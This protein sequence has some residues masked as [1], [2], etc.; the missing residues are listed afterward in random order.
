MLMDGKRQRRRIADG[1]AFRICEIFMTQGVKNTENTVILVSSGTISG[2]RSRQVAQSEL[3]ARALARFGGSML[4]DGGF[5]SAETLAE[6]T[7]ALL[8]SGGGDIHPAYYGR[9]LTGKDAARVDQRRD[10][11][12]WELLR[13]FC[14]RKKPV[15]GVCRGIQVIDVFFGGTLFQ[16]LAT[17][18]VHESTIHTVVTSEGGWLRP[19][20]G[21]SLPVNSYHHQAIRTLG[22]GLCVTAVSDADGVIE[23]I[24]HETLPVRAVQWHPERMVDGLCRDTDAE[25]GPLF[26]DFLARTAQGG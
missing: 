13:Q 25:M 14:A 21:A 12:E 18:H 4:L 16:H 20:L 22:A 10:E 9:H 1:V 11:R 23:A 3:Y 2:G 26:A 7:D 8:L 24:E 17:A 6:R 5:G 19:L 15:F